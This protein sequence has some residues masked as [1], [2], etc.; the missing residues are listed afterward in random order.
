[1]MYEVI[2]NFHCTKTATPPPPQT[3]KEENR[4]KNRVITVA[5]RYCKDCAV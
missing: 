5:Q 1:M 3:I 2:L 4:Q